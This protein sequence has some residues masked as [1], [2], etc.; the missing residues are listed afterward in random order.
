MEYPDATLAIVGRN[1]VADVNRLRFIPGVE[2]FPSV[3]DVR[4]YLADS[5]VAIA[6]LRVARGI[7]NKVL[8][9]MASGVPVIASPQAL[10]G[11]DV[12]SGEHAIVA[13]SPESWASEIVQLFEHHAERARLA[14]AGR[15]F[16]VE[17]H[18]WSACLAS[19][20]RLIDASCAHRSCRPEVVR[21]S[22]SM[23]VSETV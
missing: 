21:Q 10:E 8:E 22:R 15:K 9:A 1:P 6:P 12:C 5:S 7:Q 11:L 19:L 17:R 20:G 16:V 2:I 4:P 14:R 18:R 13:E 23:A 3:P